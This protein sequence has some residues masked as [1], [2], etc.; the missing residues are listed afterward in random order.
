MTPPFPLSYCPLPRRVYILASLRPYGGKLS[1][2]SV[3]LK[4]RCFYPSPSFPFPLIGLLS[5]TQSATLSWLYVSYRTWSL[6]FISIALDLA[7]RSLRVHAQI[8][9]G[10][11]STVHQG[12]WCR[13]N[14]CETSREAVLLDPNEYS[15]RLVRLW[16]LHGHDAAASPKVLRRSGRIGGCCS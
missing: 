2:L 3:S 11:S 10:D 6:L 8:S 9:G 7:V 13:W 14:G 4:Q 1:L 5:G 15:N 16:N 12:E